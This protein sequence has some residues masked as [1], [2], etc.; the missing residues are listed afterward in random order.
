M[1]DSIVIAQLINFAIYTL[2]PIFISYVIF[3]FFLPWLR[4][5][6]IELSKKS[7]K[8][9]LPQL[10]EFIS[11][12]KKR[13]RIYWRPFLIVWVIT[14]VIIF[15]IQ[16]FIYKTNIENYSILDLVI[17]LYFSAFVVLTSPILRPIDDIAKLAR[18]INLSYK[19]GDISYFQK[20]KIA[21]DIF[22]LSRA[23]YPSLELLTLNLNRWYSLDRQL[24]KKVFKYVQTRIES[25]SSWFMIAQKNQIKTLNIIAILKQLALAY[26]SYDI[27]KIVNIVNTFPTT[28][29][30]QTKNVQTIWL[31][32][33]NKLSIAK[34]MTN[35]LKFM[36]ENH[37]AI[38]SIIVLI[39]LVALLISGNY[40]YAR[41]FLV[42]W[43]AR[44]FPV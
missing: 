26:A 19:K 2:L 43:F 23:L 15:A 32:E 21:D 25:F 6:D 36:E 29:Q 30:I 1:V 24:R 37:N 42:Q 10:P 16:Y 28:K 33:G 22:L 27:D 7:V 35:G 12:K 31:E 11:G 4:F 20:S 41:D 18:K 13:L 44:I 5:F 14:L 34:K 39:F 3:S 17:S 9:K 38:F 8:R 40:I